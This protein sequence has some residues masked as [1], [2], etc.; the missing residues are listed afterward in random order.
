MVAI[1]EKLQPF[2]D[3]LE[4][5][6]FGGFPTFPMPSNR[7]SHGRDKPS[8]AQKFLPRICC[9]PV[10]PGREFTK[11]DI[12]ENTK[13]E[14]DGRGALLANALRNAGI[15]N[16]VTEGAL[17]PLWAAQEAFYVCSG[18]RSGRPW[19]ALLEAHR[20]TASSCREYH[21]KLAEYCH[22]ALRNPDLP[23][24]LREPVGYA[25]GYFDGVVKAARPHASQTVAPECP[26]E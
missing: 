11:G 1:N 7:K 8:D 26:N 10:N 15:V 3:E 20:G 25:W 5:I 2:T 18:Q 13:I 4:R 14:G 21:R 23:V 16:D 24:E 12:M 22:R 19:L 17:N 9:H 6:G